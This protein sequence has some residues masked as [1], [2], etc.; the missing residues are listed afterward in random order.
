MSKLD[1]KAYKKVL[2]ELNEVYPD[3]KHIM[4]AS[5]LRYQLAY[6]KEKGYIEYFKEGYFNGSGEHEFTDARITAL[7]I[8]HLISLEQNKVGGYRRGLLRRIK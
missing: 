2:T 8:D 4:N 6:L 7:G 5:Q 3:K 1:P